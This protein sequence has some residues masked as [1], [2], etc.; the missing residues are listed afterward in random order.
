VLDSE[1]IGPD[2]ELL[3][4]L[5]HPLHRQ[6]AAGDAPFTDAVDT[7]VGLHLD[8]EEIAKP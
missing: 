6:F 4:V 7:G 1:G 3:V 8:D 2:Q 5:D